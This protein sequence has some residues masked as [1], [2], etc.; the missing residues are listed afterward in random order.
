MNLAIISLGSNLGNRLENLREA[1]NLLKNS[2]AKR[3]V[4]SPVYESTAVGYSSENKFYNAVVSFYVEFDVFKLLEVVQSIEQAMGRLRV[5]KSYSD[6]IID[7]DIIFFENLTIDTQVLTL[8]HPRFQ[9]RLFVLLPLRDIQA[10]TNDFIA[11]IGIDELIHNCGSDELI[12][13]VNY[14]ICVG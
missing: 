9:S 6:R 12:D 4:C 14:T 13:K 7:L 11:T 8:P 2:G 10:T 1:V 5:S 3:V